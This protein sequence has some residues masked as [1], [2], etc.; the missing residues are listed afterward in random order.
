[1]NLVCDIYSFKESLESLFS[2]CLLVHDCDY[3]LGRL[4]PL[5]NIH[6]LV[7]LSG[8]SQVPIIIYMSPSTFVALP[9]SVCVCVCVW[10]SEQVV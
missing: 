6:Y 9:T 2:V 8:L 10:S 7:C 5:S 4:E 1:M 3:S